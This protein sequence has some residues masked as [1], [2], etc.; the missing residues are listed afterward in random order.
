MLDSTFMYNWKAHLI[1]IRRDT[2]AYERVDIDLGRKGAETGFSELFGFRQWLTFLPVKLLRIN[3]NN[4]STLQWRY[5]MVILVL[6][7]L[8]TRWTILKKAPYLKSGTYM[9]TL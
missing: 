5:T 1:V 9:S 4:L 8:V 6:L 2:G 3:F 7:H